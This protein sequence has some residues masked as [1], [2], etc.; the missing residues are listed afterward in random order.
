MKVMHAQ[1]YPF[2]P[3]RIPGGPFSAGYH[4]S[5]E[6]AALPGV[7]VNVVTVTRD[8]E[9]DLRRVDGRVPVTFLA[10]KR[11]RVIPNLLTDVP[12]IAAEIERVKPDI[13]SAQLAVYGVA[14]L[15]VN[16]PSVYLIHGVIHKEARVRTNLQDRLL[17]LLYVRM[18]H[19]AARGAKDIIATSPYV[20]DEYRHITK[21]RF[22]VIDNAVDDRYFEI[23]S[24]EETPRLLLGGLIYDRKNI[25]GAL[26]IVRRLKGK[27]P[28]IVLTVAGRIADKKYYGK[29]TAYVERHQLQGNVVFLGQA[30][31]DQMVDELSRCSMLLLTSSQET[32]P[33]IISEA[34]AAGKP[35]VTADVGGCRYLVE[36]GASGFVVPWDDA[37]AYVQSIA[38]I[39]DDSAL[40]QSFGGR[41]REI[42][43]ARFRRRIIATLTLSIYR[44]I[45]S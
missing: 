26:E 24:R 4:L 34:M 39:L 42:A 16:V 20:I 23:D 12:K 45:L 36:D 15:K 13:V 8:V 44:D 33:L 37:A 19:A 40:R 6:M 17:Y 35:V 27:F 32:A 7:D 1:Q 22:H 5:H 14:A 25:L 9:K 28:N 3:S 11:H 18:D 43:E 10:R 2:D 38:T 21:A 29:C 31:V 30:T 41:S